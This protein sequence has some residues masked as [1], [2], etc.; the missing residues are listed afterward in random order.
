MNLTGVG[1]I[2]QVCAASGLEVSLIDTSEPALAR[3]TAAIRSSL[4]RLHSK[5][6]LKTSP[7]DVMANLETTTAIDVSQS[8]DVVDV[9][10]C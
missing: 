5:G 3:A 10:G 2:A 4:E 8:L 6:I 7:Q 9:D 1:G